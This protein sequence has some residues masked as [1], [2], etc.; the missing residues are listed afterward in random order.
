MVKLTPSYPCNASGLVL[1]RNR[2]SKSGIRTGKGKDRQVTED[3]GK[4]G[5]NGTQI[6][7]PDAHNSKDITSENQTRAIR[8]LNYP[9]NFLWCTSL[10]MAFKKNQRGAIRRKCFADISS[11]LEN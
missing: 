6:L 1:F 7:I 9:D 11:F 5:I 8:P 4:K 3:T 2:I 10:L